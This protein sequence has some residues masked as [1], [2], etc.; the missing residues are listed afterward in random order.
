MAGGGQRGAATLRGEGWP[1]GGHG[2]DVGSDGGQAPGRTPAAP[3]GARLQ[4]QYLNTY[5]ET[6][7]ARVG[8]E[9][10]RQQLE[11]EYGWLQRSTE[12]FPLA[13]AAAAAT[14]GTLGTLAL[15]PLLAGLLGG[16][17]A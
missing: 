16:L 8:A 11:E 15:A 6:I 17:Q 10:R 4:I 13:S 2:E 9:L 12:P 1:D 7:R 14:L 5:Y 3:R